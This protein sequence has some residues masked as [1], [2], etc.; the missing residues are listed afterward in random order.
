MSLK[1]S[2]LNEFKNAEEFGEYITQSFSVI[3]AQTQVS[4]VEFTKTH[5]SNLREGFY[6]KIIE[7][8]NPKEQI[9]RRFQTVIDT[10]IKSEQFTKYD[11]MEDGILYVYDE[12]NNNKLK[13][14]VTS[15]I[16]T[17]GSSSWNDII[18]GSSTQGI[19][20]N[21]GILVFVKNKNNE[22]IMIVIDAW[23]LC[24]SAVKTDDNSSAISKGE[25]RKILFANLS[26]S[27]NSSSLH[28]V[29]GSYIFSRAPDV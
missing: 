11:H 25:K 27:S 8:A 23:S 15:S 29:T 10:L 21:N 18:V 26:N 7:T 4:A 5:L 3:P 14:E 9:L 17:Y 20:R 22:L 16:V 19:S 28:L 2:I 24:G 12:K 6:L 13:T 1:Y